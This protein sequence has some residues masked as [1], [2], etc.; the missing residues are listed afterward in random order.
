IEALAPL[1]GADRSLRALA[2]VDTGDVWGADQAVLFSQLRYATGFGIAWVSPVGP[3]KLS[4]AFPLHRQPTDFIQR[5][6]F[7]IG[8]GF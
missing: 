1:P 7:Q 2:F 5:F 6:Q 4:I 3:L 8:T